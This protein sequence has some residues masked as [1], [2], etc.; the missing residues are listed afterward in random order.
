MG[1]TLMIDLPGGPTES[2]AI[3]AGE[4]YLLGRD[5]DAEK[6]E[7]PGRAR[8]VVLRSPSVSANHFLVRSDGHQ[9]TVTDAGSRNGTWLKLPP[10]EPIGVI[11]PTVTVRLSPGSATHGDG[12]DSA[13]QTPRWTGSHD[14]HLGIADVVSAWLREKGVLARVA[15]RTARGEN[16]NELWARGEIPLANGMRLEVSSV[17]TDDGRWQTLLTS[18]WRWSTQMNALYREE[19]D[20][21]N[22]G[23]ILAS[24]AIRRAHSLV[25]DAAKR[26]L[27]LL[28][29]GP[30]GSG[31][32]GLARAYHRHSA[33][34]GA[35]VA[36][37]CSM[38]NRE[39]LRSELFGAE[40][41]AF[42]TAVRRIVGAVESANGGTLFLDEIGEMPLDVQP[43]LL[44]FLDRGEYERM[45]GGP[46][47][48][49]DVQLVC[50]TNKDLRTSTTAGE[51]R[52]DLWYRIA[53]QVVEVP[54]LRERPEDVET[55]L[56]LHRMPDGN[57]A[58]S[59]LSPAARAR[60]LA[61]PLPG[62]FRALANFVGKLP[63]QA[64]PESVSAQTCDALL[65]DARPGHAP[66]P[67]V[68]ETGGERRPGLAVLAS[69]AAAAY[70]EDHA[71]V[72]GRWDE[73]KEYIERYLKPLLYAHLGGVA[74]TA[75]EQVS[76][77]DVAQ[78]LESDRGTAQKQLN[79]YFE[80]FLR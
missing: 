80:R 27:R 74:N 47:R 20:S 32:D 14:F 28:L 21:R 51:F 2:L 64:E 52:E 1:T 24:P 49:A 30:S 34:G 26:G 16:G 33:R 4:T 42:T 79:R 19:E 60:L 9:V 37:N 77:G 29:L 46:V 48:R 8:A 40:Q 58:H 54:P 75:K 73:V 78:V 43:L 7:A 56:R 70:E 66:H 41:G 13:P 53:G 5:P 55:Y 36:K 68:N 25:T 62:N 59:I 44:T 31:K 76:P 71:A 35:F 11:A 57:D 72:P 18:L 22:E 67:R 65:R 17:E 45:G 3:E 61:D 6:L 38:F 50:A 12:V 15:T 63:S 10:G 23:F 69:A 39:L